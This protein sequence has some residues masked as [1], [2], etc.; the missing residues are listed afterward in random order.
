MKRAGIDQDAFL[1]IWEELGG[2]GEVESPFLRASRGQEA[3][4]VGREG[5]GGPPGVLG[6]V[7][8]PPR[9]PAGAGR[10]SQRDGRG[11]ESLPVGRESLPE[12][13]RGREAFRRAGRC[14][15]EVDGNPVDTRK[16]DRCSRGRMESWLKFMET[17]TATRNVFGK[18]SGST[19]I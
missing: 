15:A 19:N 11:Q 2:P 4:Y 17:P 10:P 12:C 1:E 13:G 9:G 5:S 7:G 14:R 8:G 16:F 6:V 3:L 18:S